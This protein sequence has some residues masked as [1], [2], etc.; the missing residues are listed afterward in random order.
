MSTT[1]T[2]K[3]RK[4]KFIRGKHGEPMYPM[5]MT[6]PQMRGV[7]EALE[8]FED[9]GDEHDDAYDIVDDSLQILIAAVEDGREAV[10]G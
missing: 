10:H 4:A 2:K 1:M 6:E 7:L 3:L 9:G 5:H 8:A